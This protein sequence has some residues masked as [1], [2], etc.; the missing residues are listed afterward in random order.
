[1]MFGGSISKDDEKDF[2]RRIPVDLTALVAGLKLHPN[3][4]EETL[5]KVRGLVSDHMPFL[6]EDTSNNGEDQSGRR[7][8]LTPAPDT[9]GHPSPPPRTA[10]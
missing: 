10:P 5:N 3:A 1:M 6:G 9:T 4:T 8:D 2:A 7:G